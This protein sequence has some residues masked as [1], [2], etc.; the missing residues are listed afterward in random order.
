MLSVLRRPTAGFRLLP[1]LALLSVFMLIKPDSA[2]AQASAVNT[3][4]NST[5][6]HTTF[7]DSFQTETVDTFLTRIVARLD[8][9][10]TVYD[11]SFNLAFGSAT[12]Q[13]AVVAAQAALN[14]AVDPDPAIAGPT[15]ISSQTVLADTQTTTTQSDGGS[16]VTA[17]AEVLV[18]PNTVITGNRDLGGVPVPV[19]AGT[20]NT[21][22]NID[23]EFLINRVYLTTNTYLT[24]Q[25]Y[26][27]V[28]YPREVVA[29]VPEPASLG[30]L[31]LGLAGLAALRRRRAVEQAG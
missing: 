24:S 11:Q 8:G 29:S 26:E 28:G 4:T 30:L 22:I 18:G 6:S 15:L 2:W 5:S 13:A 25:E 9:G 1:V 31:G 19:P 17:T 3:T 20:V 12:V 27:L 16:I 23:T 21:N 7:I 14:A 10:A